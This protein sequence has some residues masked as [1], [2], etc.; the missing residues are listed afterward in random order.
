MYIIVSAAHRRHCQPACILPVSKLPGTWREK[1]RAIT[2]PPLRG[3]SAPKA[4]AAFGLHGDPSLTS[5]MWLTPLNVRF[6]RLK[7]SLFLLE[8]LNN[9][10]KLKP[11]SHL[12]LRRAVTTESLR[13]VR[14]LH[15]RCEEWLQMIVPNLLIFS[16]S[17]YAIVSSIKTGTCCVRAQRP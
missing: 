9:T 17:S 10:G 1:L 6:Q 2:E 15:D 5:R 7:K 3:V 14:K 16:T 13:R 11:L 4:A 12:T 8:I